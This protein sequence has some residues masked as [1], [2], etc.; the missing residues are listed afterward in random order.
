MVA[1]LQGQQRQ[2]PTAASLQL[3]AEQLQQLQVQLAYVVNEEARR[4]ERAESG[5]PPSDLDLP[6]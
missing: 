2:R 6:L 3:N 1:A 5:L 4:P